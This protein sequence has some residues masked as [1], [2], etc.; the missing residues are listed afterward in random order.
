MAG[1]LVVHMAAA[2]AQA[3]CSNFI[4][5]ILPAIEESLREAV[6]PDDHTKTLGKTPDV[7]LNLLRDAPELSIP[8]LAASL[9]KS[10]SAVERA[11]RKLREVGRL[12]RIGPDKGGH[13]QVLD[14]NHLDRP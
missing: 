3:D 2:D 10:Q 11:I 5:F 12:K 13:W 6:N 14:D 7:I 1:D 8:Q 4:E 9:G